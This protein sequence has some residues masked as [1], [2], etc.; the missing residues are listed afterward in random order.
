MDPEVVAQA[1]AGIVLSV[2]VIVTA[3]KAGAADKQTRNTGNGFASE[4]LTA[5][6][7]IRTSQKEHRTHLQRM[8][9]RF[10]RHLE[11][12]TERNTG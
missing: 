2:G 10:D 5:L 4:V 9:A 1:I 8:E 11:H 6:A 12:H 3:K 7:E